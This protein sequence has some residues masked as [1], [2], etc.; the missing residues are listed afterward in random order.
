VIVLGQ[1]QNSVRSISVEP[2]VGLQ[3]AFIGKGHFE[4]KVIVQ[5]QMY[6]D[7]ISSPICISW[8]IAGIWKYLL[9]YFS[10]YFLYC[11]VDLFSSCLTK[12]GSTLWSHLRLK[13]LF[14]F[15][16]LW[17][18]MIVFDLES[19]R[20]IHEFILVHDVINT[21]LLNSYWTWMFCSWR[22]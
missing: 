4:V 21:F 10:I 13:Q 8:T 19:T 5:D 11:W 17:G 9:K 6:C 16:E 22:M 20:L 2:H 14:P 7:Q 1:A 15:S 12:V 3:S 18:N